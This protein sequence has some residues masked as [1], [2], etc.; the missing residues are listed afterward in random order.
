MEE[1]IAHTA[2]AIKLHP[3]SKTLS[4]MYFELL[5]ES[6]EQ[7]K[8]RAEIRRFLRLREWDE[9]LEVIR[10]NGWKEADFR[11]KRSRRSA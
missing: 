5:M 3:T 9:Y 1:A 2:S 11:K 6:G 10:E 8:A 4:I 7:R